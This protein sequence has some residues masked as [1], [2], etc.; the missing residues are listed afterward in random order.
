M[1]AR[2][3]AVTRTER[4]AF[5]REQFEQARADALDA[6]YDFNDLCQAYKVTP[7]QLGDAAQRAILAA[8]EVRMA[9]RSVLLDT[10]R[11]RRTA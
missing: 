3:A 4:K 11:A 10:P 8:A 5:L 7:K 1:G 2:G 6:A 9:A